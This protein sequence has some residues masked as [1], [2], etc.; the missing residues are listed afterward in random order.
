MNH[1]VVTN[2]SGDNQPRITPK[3]NSLIERMVVA[4]ERIK[5]SD[6]KESDIDPSQGSAGM[7]VAVVDALEEY[8]GAEICEEDRT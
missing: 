2:N 3:S 1:D 8:A 7:V 6:N 4:A 5:N